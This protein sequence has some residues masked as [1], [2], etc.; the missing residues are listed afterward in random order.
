MTELL[1]R[2][3]FSISL[4]LIL[5][6]HQ[7]NGFIVIAESGKSELAHPLSL[8]QGGEFFMSVITKYWLE[9]VLGGVENIAII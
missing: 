6:L 4:V 1:Q 5:Q 7:V 9:L 3:E 2:T 8:C